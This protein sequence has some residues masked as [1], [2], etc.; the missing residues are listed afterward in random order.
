MQEKVT[1]R[2]RNYSNNVY[3]VHSTIKRHHGRL[4][5]KEKGSVA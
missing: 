3:Y 5:D 1:I 2:K 4:Q